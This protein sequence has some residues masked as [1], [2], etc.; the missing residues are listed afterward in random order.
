VLVAVAVAVVVV[1]VVGF[2]WAAVG[3]VDV[4]RGGWRMRGWEGCLIC[5]MMPPWMIDLSER[6]GWGR[7][8]WVI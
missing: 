5:L 4:R 2:S 3:V 1:V 6:M 7:V 8:G